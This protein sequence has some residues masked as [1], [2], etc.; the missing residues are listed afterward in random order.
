[1][2]QSRNTLQPISLAGFILVILGAGVSTFLP[3]LLYF[4]GLPFWV[5]LAGVLLVWFS[6]RKITTKLLWTLVP[7]AVFFIYQFASYQ[8]DRITP[9]TFLIPEDY[10]GT[11]RIIFNEPCGAEPL[12]EH[13]RRLYQIPAEG[14]LI[15]KFKDEYGIIDQEYYL[16]GDGGKRRRIYSMNTSDF[17]EVWTYQKSPHE[18]SRDS[19]GIFNMATSGIFTDSDNSGYAYQECVVCT[20]RQLRDSFGFSYKR[21]FDSLQEVVLK[22]CRVK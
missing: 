6:R 21:K 17:N 7:V 19:L 8:F 5:F 2:T 4:Y 22:E 9:E 1:M 10:R 12:M 3:G 13:G 15:T 20:Y 14:I 16:V 18:P 11:V